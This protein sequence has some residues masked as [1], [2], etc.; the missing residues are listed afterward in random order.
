MSEARAAVRPGSRWKPIAVAAAAALGVATLGGLLTDIGPWYQSLRFPAWK[1]PDFLFGPAWTTIFACA[2]A[3][4]S[5][6]WR[7]A[8]R[9][10]RE[11]ILALF[12][13]NAFFNVSWSLLFFRLRRPDWALA[14]VA[15]LWLS[16]AL[17]IAFFA[18]F[19][20]PS[21]WLLAPYLVWVS[22]AAA[23]NLAIVRLNG[24][25]TG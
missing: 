23:L 16:V 4:G 3:A 20:R 18:R 7:R 8:S 13:M 10:R 2:A 25:F 11:W 14:E 6:G 19:S 21:A 24:P 17:L 5:I 15:L 1:P 22:F 9:Q 12:A